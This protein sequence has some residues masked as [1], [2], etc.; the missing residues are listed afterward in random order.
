MQRQAGTRRTPVDCLHI[1]Q[2]G[3]KLLLADTVLF[4]QANQQRCVLGRNRI[5][6]GIHLQNG[7]EVYITP[8]S[9]AWPKMTEN[10]HN[11]AYTRR[12]QVH[13]SPKDR[14]KLSGSVPQGLPGTVT[15]TNAPR[16]V[17]KNHK[18][19]NM[20]KLARISLHLTKQLTMSQE[21]CGMGRLISLHSPAP[22]AGLA[23]H[24]RRAGLRAAR[25]PE[26]VVNRQ[27]NASVHA[28]RT[29]A[30]QKKPTA[31]RQ[32]KTEPVPRSTAPLEG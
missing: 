3:K 25:L 8:A 6:I 28:P 17:S 26:S 16:K 29:R 20:A 7:H 14:H 31:G 2:P 10:M 5:F 22:R 15:P 19:K 18:V 27:G 9:R 21:K 1:F 13:W 4:H 30:Q 23:R 32:G 12:L 11:S 24:S